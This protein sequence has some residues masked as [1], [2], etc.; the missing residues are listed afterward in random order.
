M[1]IVDYV[2]IVTHWKHHHQQSRYDVRHVNSAK[3]VVTTSISISYHN[4]NS[5][6]DEFAMA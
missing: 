3:V 6:A 1:H 5:Q 2:I 4:E